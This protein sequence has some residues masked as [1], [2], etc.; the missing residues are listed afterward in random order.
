MNS[1]KIRVDAHCVQLHFDSTGVSNPDMHFPPELFRVIIYFAWNSIIDYQARKKL[2]TSS[3]LVSKQWRHDFVRI[4]QENIHFPISLQIKSLKSTGEALRSQNLT[5]SMNFTL[6]STPRKASYFNWDSIASERFPNMKIASFDLSRNV[7]G[8]PGLERNWRWLANLPPQTDTLEFIKPP[9]K[10]VD[11]H[12][13]YKHD[14]PDLLNPDDIHDKYKN[15]KHLRFYGMDNDAIAWILLWPLF[16]MLQ[17]VEVDTGFVERPPVL[18]YRMTK[19]VYR[20]W[21]EN[22]ASL[23]NDLLKMNDLYFTFLTRVKDNYSIACFL[24]QREDNKLDDV[25]TFIMGGSCQTE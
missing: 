13:H 18:A 22:R 24:G 6:G 7:L 2:A 23:K 8:F 4:S 16:P 19:E 25:L 10:M 14:L 20:V 12:P 9:P 3:L 21:F 5:T 15:I 11:Y 1:A 17:T